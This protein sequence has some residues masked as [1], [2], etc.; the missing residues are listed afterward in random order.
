MESVETVIIGAGLS[1]IYA[2]FLLSQKNREYLVLEARSSAGG[3]ILGLE[4]EGF[5]TDMGPSWYWPDIHPK[6]TQI[7]NV[8]GISGYRQYEDGLGRFQS[9]DGVIHTVRGYATEPP[10]WRVAGGLSNLV[11]ALL[12]HIPE[13]NIRLNQQ[14]CSIEKTE[15]AVLAG[16]GNPEE[17]PISLFKAKKVI[18]AIPP[19]LAASTIL[20]TPELPYDLT[21]AMLKTGTWM[22]GQAKF[23][24][25]YDKPFWRDYGLSGQAFSQYGPIG[26]IHDGSNDDMSPY[27][28][29][30]FLGVPAVRRNNEKELKTAM[31]NQLALLY[32]EPAENPTAFLYQDWAKE[33]Y[34]AT[35]YDQPPM[36]S[37]PFYSP[38]AGKISIWDD[39]VRFAG[40]E[41]AEQHGGYMEGAII[42]AKRA[43]MNI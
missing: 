22:A 41:T 32:G 24:A 8:L 17:E 23:C 12:N 38:P 33:K 2:A 40:T 34:T 26:E 11:S 14:V 42:A 7:L 6:I 20:F 10:S 9:H 4:H 36:L 21:Q 3:R 30:G 31:I 18:L 19:R 1:G 25:L 37:H 27:G 5:V 16:V 35:Q 43:V 15:S 13:K 39:S 28:L 29:M